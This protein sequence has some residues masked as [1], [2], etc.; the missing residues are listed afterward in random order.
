LSKRTSSHVMR[1][2]VIG[3]LCTSIACSG[4]G[5]LARERALGG[6][7]SGAGAGAALGYGGAGSSTG[8]S[9]GGSGAE[10]QIAASV[11]LDPLATTRRNATWSLNYWTWSP[12][13]GDA[14]SGT[15]SAVAALAP[16]LLRLGGYNNDANTPDAFYE[17]ALDRAVA[18]ARAIGAEPLLQRPCFSTHR[19]N[20]PRRK[21]PFIS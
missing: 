21:N 13:Y 17:A 4:Q 15:E 7:T 20:G 18:Y 16:A 19:D 2:C 5:T 1:A 6:S 14:V 10:S 9:V 3:A 12:T 8:A 11:T